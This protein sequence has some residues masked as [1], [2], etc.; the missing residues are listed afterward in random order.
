[1]ALLAL[2]CLLVPSAAVASSEAPLAPG[3]T[4][5][6]RIVNGKGTTIDK[7]PWQVALLDRRFGSSQTSR[8]FCSG[9]LIADDLVI[10]AAHCVADYR[11]GELANLAVIAG[12]TYLKQKSTGESLSV[13]RVIMARDAEGRRKYRIRGGAAIWDVALLKLETPTALGSAIAIAGASEQ[14]SWK[15][16]RLVK[17]TGWGYTRGA[18]GSVSDRLRMANQVILPDGV[19]RRSGF[20][21]S[22]TMICLGGPRGGSS[23]C[24]G[25]SGGPLVTPVGDGWRLV[26]MTSFGDF[27]CRGYIPSV[28]NRTA[29]DPVRSWVQEKA[30]A[31]SGQDPVAEGGEIGPLPP[32]CKVPA[33]AGKTRKSAGTTLRKAGCRLRKVRKVGRPSQRKGRVVGTSLPEGWLAPLDFGITIRVSR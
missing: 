17:T 11:P 6:P 23:A 5:Q 32:S 15:P 22:T 27:F 31:V 30:I 2:S 26:G 4:V 20:Y 7:W 19:C 18:G 14:A 9:S 8:Y 12:R 13:K 1:V 25:D 33:L 16:G 3:P 29:A 10:T 28:D 21:E 24:S